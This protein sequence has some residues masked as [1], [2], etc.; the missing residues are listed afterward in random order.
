LS[1]LTGIEFTQAEFTGERVIPELVDSDLLN[2]HL[3]RYRF[4]N[5]VAAG[6]QKPVHILDAGCGSG[7]GTAELS[8]AA[9]VTAADIS[10]E[11]VVHAREHYRRP[12]AHFLQAACEAMPFAPGAFDLVLAFEVIEHLDSWRELLIEANRVLKPSGVLLVSTPN[13]DYYAES[14]GDAGPNPFHRHEF[15]YEE[16]RQS[17][18]AIFAHVRIWTQNHA[19]AIVFSPDH[20]RGAALEMTGSADP[21]GAHFYL[22]ACS[23]SPL[24]SDPAQVNPSNAAEGVVPWKFSAASGGSCALDEVFAW[25]PSGANLLRERERHIDKLKGELEKKDAWLRENIEAHGELQR[26]HEALTAELQRQN[27]WAVELNREISLR[28]ARIGELQDEQTARLTWIADLESQLA[29]ARAEIGR[30][31]SESG[32]LR[33]QAQSEI[34]RLGAENSELR[35]QAQARIERLEA[36]V[37]ERT[38]WAQRLDAEI[39]EYREELR[40]I[41]STIWFRAGAKLGLGPR[42]RDGK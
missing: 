10:A 36:T 3:A 34:S 1:E 30:L 8:A 14:R 24:A 21:A 25:L 29:R 16:F 12:G 6:M 37:A 18:G 28:N 35:Q 7:Y 9:S 26:R 38:Q 40:R 27:D 5:R 41:A 20:P 2:E 11:A 23:Q 19:E 17:L 39:A 15:D 22:A 4:A 32:E 42:L 33:Q 13:R 31:A